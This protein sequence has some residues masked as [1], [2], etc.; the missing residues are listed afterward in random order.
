MSTIDPI[1]QQIPA[2]RTPLCNPDGTAAQPWLQFWMAL[3]RRTGSATGDTGQV[4]DFIWGLGDDQGLS[5]GGAQP[6]LLLDF[7]DQSS[8]PSDQELG[9]FDSSE[10]IQ[11]PDPM[12]N[13]LMAA[14]QSESSVLTEFL[15]AGDYI[16]IQSSGGNAT[17]SALAGGT[18]MRLGALD[19]A[20]TWT[21]QNIFTDFPLDATDGAN[22]SGAQVTAVDGLAVSGAPL[23]ATNGAGFLGGTTTDTLHVD[24]SVGSGNAVIDGTLLVH[25]RTTL[26]VGLDVG[27]SGGVSTFADGLAVS[28]GILSGANG[29]SA[30]GGLTADSLHVTAGTVL[31]GG[32]TGSGGITVSGAVADFAAGCNVANTLTAVNGCLVDFFNCTGGA[33]VGGGFAVTGGIASAGSI[34]PVPDNIYSLGAPSNRFTDVYAVSG[35]V[36]PSDIRLKKNVLPMPN[37]LDLIEA[38]QPIT[39]EWS[40]P[41]WDSRTHWGFMAQQV[42][43]E[44]GEF[45]RDFAGHLVDSEGMHALRP[46]EFIGVLWQA[47]RELKA[48]VEALQQVAPLAPLGG[49]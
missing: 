1:Q 48:K 5:S 27:G 42:A 34:V 4:E 25:G 30:L 2:P 13:A 14:D 47:V 10:P 40:D 18:G 38:I 44:F 6:E 31:S 45:G 23:F 32:V 20:N 11:F 16:S 3:W 9:L 43:L 21:K 33:T 28:G 19:Q 41:T 24:H 49:M 8:P 39:F 36:N 37:V 7:G 35:S 26:V 17:I 15:S 22:F 46:H 12:L 29:I